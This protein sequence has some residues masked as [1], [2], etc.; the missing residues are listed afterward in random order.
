MTLSPIEF[1]RNNWKRWVDEFREKLAI[2]L[3]P[4][5]VYQDVLDAYEERR[6]G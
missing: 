6:R 1:L 2:R 5:I 3:A 4:W